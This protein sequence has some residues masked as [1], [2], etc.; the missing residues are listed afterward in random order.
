MLLEGKVVVVSGVGPGLG[1]EIALAAS[2]EGA[3]VVLGA[4]REENLRATAEEI[5]AAGGTAAWSRTDITNAD[6]CARLIATAADTFGGVDA[7]VNCAAYD[8]AFGGLE[9][10][11]LDEWRQVFETNVFGTLGVC[12]A[13]IPHLKDGGGAIVFIGSQGMFWPQVMQMAYQSSKASLNAAMYYL[14][15]ELGPHKV[16]VN[17]V[18]P[19]WMWGPPVEAYVDMTSQAQGISKDEVIAGIT[20]NMPLGE[21]PSDGDIAEVVV[22]FCSDRAR[23]VTMQTLLVNAGEFPH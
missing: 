10:A 21:I 12:K 16:R 1:R 9:E 19:T 13:A 22:F 23:M 15:K 6:D 18:V 7:V 11:D 5:E 4:R 17:T 2:R 20:Q 14:A 3:S 8:T